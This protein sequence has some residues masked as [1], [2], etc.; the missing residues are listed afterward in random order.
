MSL[1]QRSS[2]ILFILFT[3]FLIFTL[4][5]M[6]IVIFKC[7]PIIIFGIN[8]LYQSIII[9]KKNLNFDIS[10][11]NFDVFFQFA[12]YHQFMILNL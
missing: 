3:K 6:H 5:L 1:Y 2:D 8:F 10:R 9:V 12:Y 4:I 7:F 11:V